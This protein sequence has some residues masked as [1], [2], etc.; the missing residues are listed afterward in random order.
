ML[1]V[2]LA[3]AVAA[4]PSAPPPQ[5]APAAAKDADPIVCRMEPLEGS[6]ITHKVCRRASDLAQ[7]RQDARQALERLQGTMPVTM[8]MMGP[9]H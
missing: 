4:A 7:N 2:I 5:P 9:M 6:R 1:G 3:A 8:P